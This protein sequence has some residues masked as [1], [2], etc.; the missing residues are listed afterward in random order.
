M[1]GGWRVGENDMQRMKYV[2]LRTNKAFKCPIIPPESR[3][4]Q[5]RLW[6]SGGHT[7]HLIQRFSSQEEG[8][9]S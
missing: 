1:K 7:L 6:T 5:A 4:S 9:S 8:R 3:I 2:N